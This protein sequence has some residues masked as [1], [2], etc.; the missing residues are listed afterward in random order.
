MT[1]DIKKGG[2]QREVVK[3]VQKPSRDSR[4]NTK[5]E[6]SSNPLAADLGRKMI[7]IGQPSIP[8]DIIEFE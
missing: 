7:S 6:Q 3:H 2:L 8:S 4:R 1:S 5:I